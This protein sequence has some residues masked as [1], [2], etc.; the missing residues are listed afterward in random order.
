MGWQERES[1]PL[2]DCDQ[3][4][5]GAR[6][7]RGGRD[8]VRPRRVSS[9]APPRSG[10]LVTVLSAVAMVVGGFEACFAAA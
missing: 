3:N 7:E 2:G 6:A 4:V 1:I 9:A 5:G 10:A 8:S